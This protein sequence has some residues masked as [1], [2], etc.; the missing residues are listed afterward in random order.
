MYK[1]IAND[2]I[3]NFNYGNL[4]IQKDRYNNS[5]LIGAV[6][7]VIGI[8]VGIIL[9]LMFDIFEKIS[10]SNIIVFLIKDIFKERYILFYLLRCVKRIWKKRDIIT[11]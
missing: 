4:N 3:Y 9:N 1:L 10:K 8:V 5:L 6:V 7:S 11:L 2:Y